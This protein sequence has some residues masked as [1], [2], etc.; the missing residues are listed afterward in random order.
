MANRW[1]DPRA[2]ALSLAKR[3]AKCEQAIQE[4]I[5]ESGEALKRNAQTLTDGPT[6]HGDSK[7]TTTLP[8]GKRTGRLHNAFSVAYTRA[9]NKAT[10]SLFNDAPEAKFTI[11]DP[12]RG[13]HKAL[14]TFFV[15][16]QRRINQKLSNRIRAIMKG[17]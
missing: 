3:F 1:T 5:Y 8:I 11:M 7:G 6:T 13:F 12:R 15:S 17:R 16:D 4:S 9:M 14:Y 10:A 2:M